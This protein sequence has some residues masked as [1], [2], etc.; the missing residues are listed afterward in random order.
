MELSP[1]VD[2]FKEPAKELTMWWIWLIV[3]AGALIAAALL[4]L[5]YLGASAADTNEEVQRRGPS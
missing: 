5:G 4:A 3:I 1:R 2:G